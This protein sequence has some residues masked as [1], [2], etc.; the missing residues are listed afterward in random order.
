M[1]DRNFSILRRF[2]REIPYLITT[3]L[4]LAT[5]FIISV[6]I[7]KN[8]GIHDRSVYGIATVTIM[9]VLL[10]SQ[11]GLPG[12][13][14]IFG[15]HIFKK[16]KLTWLLRLWLSKL[17]FIGIA[18]GFY[19]NSQAFDYFVAVLV[20]LNC[21]ILIPAQWIFN[22]LQQYVSRNNFFLLRLVPSVT[23]LSIVLA[24]H[25]L[26]IQNLRNFLISWVL[27][28]IIF[29]LVSLRVCQ[30]KMQVFSASPDRSVFKKLLKNGYAGFIPH[31]SI[32][33]ILKIEYLLIP[34]V[35]S[36]LFSASYFAIVGISSWPKAICD[37][38]AISNFNTILKTDTFRKSDHIRRV[39]FQ[40]S[41]ILF[42]AILINLCVLFEVTTIFPNH[43]KSNLWAIIP[44]TLSAT[45]SSSR[46]L[47]LDILRVKG[48]FEA[49]KATSI[50]IA[51]F[52]PIFAANIFLFVD[53]SLVTWSYFVAI[54]SLFGLLITIMKIRV[55]ANID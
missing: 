20:L 18:V 14:S 8:L 52:I 6:T 39:L 49:K 37:S 7:T 1:Q 42:S 34:L 17:S 27:S 43:Y 28:N 44:L 29:L 53:I 15:F 41:I 22:S 26:K 51:A 40:I 21:A 13:F 46:R 33:E 50:E 55:H 5:A 32:Q 4:G 23:Q 2:S 25:S 54:A 38:V 48:E 47:F 16:I 31:I 3:F 9:Q 12:S 10:I 11:L 24:I 30:I 45:F 35:K 36:P 19:L